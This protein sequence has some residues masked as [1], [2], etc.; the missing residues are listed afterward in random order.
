MKKITIKLTIKDIETAIRHAIKPEYQDIITKAILDN[1][2]DED[3]LLENFYLASNNITPKLDYFVGQEIYV[4]YGALNTW[5]F[6]IEKCKNNNILIAD[7]YFSCTIIST[8]PFN[9]YKKYYVKYKAVNQEDQL[10]ELYSYISDN[11]I[12][13][14]VEEFPGD[15]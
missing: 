9:T 4:E 8:H 10:T 7:K 1:C 13:G 15:N 14:L 5:L 11:Y 6:N 3:K 12:E 2:I